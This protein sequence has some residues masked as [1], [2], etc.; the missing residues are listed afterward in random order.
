MTTKK[1]K[2]LIY[3]PACRQPQLLGNFRRLSDSPL[4]YSDFCKSCEHHHGAYSLYKDERLARAVTPAAREFVLSEDEAAEDIENRAQSEQKAVEKEMARRELMRRRLIY[5]VTQ[6]RHDYL[7]GWVHQDICR[8]LERFVKQVERKESPRL[9]LF[10]PPRAGKS[11]LV[12]DEFPSWVFGHH[13][14]W[15]FISA[16]YAVSLPIGFS[17]RI[18]DR[19]DD[20]AYQAVFPKTKV[21]NDSRGVEEWLTTEGG[22][23]RAA[24]VEGGITGTG[25]N[26]LN[27]DDPIKDYQEAQSDVVRANAYNWYT[28]TARTRL[29][30]GGGVLITQTRWHDADLAG[31]LL[32]D[33]EALIEAGVP[34][35]EIDQWEVVSYPALAEADEYL[36]PNGTIEVGPAEVPDG[37]RLLRREGEALHPERYSAKALRTIRNTMPPV[38][39]NALYQ[40][41]PVPADGEF[42]TSEMFRFYNYLP[43]T[44]EEYAWFAAWDLAI[45]QKAQN[46]YTV[47]VV[48]A[49]HSD[50]GLYVV[51]MI[52]GRLSTYPIVESMVKLGDK[53]TLLQIQGIEDGQIKKTLMPLLE[54]EMLKAKSKFSFDEELKPVTDKLLR[55]RPL[56]QRMQMGQVYL[57]AGQP[58][59]MKIQQEMLRFPS[60]THDDMVDAMAWLARMALRITPP[61]PP[62]HRHRRARS[63]WRK[64]LHKHT[65]QA[66]D[67]SFMTA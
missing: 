18:R 34:E 35:D 19:L 28:T 48:G 37:A 50:G 31:R 60:G 52:R 9:M 22:R 65:Q 39:W 25:C 20:K 3:C 64:E 51:D 36:F 10:M 38:Q 27:I 46:D 66:A 58:W 41:N 61:M 7:A 57:P 26:I 11:T 45:G 54:K 5:Y 4:L 55:A 8:R 40:Q 12:S 1:S 15:E 56:Q 47:G 67:S 14:E 29:A 17:R 13:P 43:G 2:P 23:F 49:L 59:A 53:W 6:F 21:R 32:T 44:A 33:R 16:S 63:S 62:T 30:P 42:F 24:G